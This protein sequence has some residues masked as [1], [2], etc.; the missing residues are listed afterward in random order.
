M[1]LLRGHLLERDGSR[2]KP[3]VV[4]AHINSGALS[5]LQIMVG[6]AWY[7]GTGKDNMDLT[8][9][10]ED[11]L[12]HGYAAMYPEYASLRTNTTDSLSPLWDLLT[13][14]KSAA[15]LC[16]NSVTSSSSPLASR[17]S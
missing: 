10:S 8:M 2:T 6:R 7:E 15:N 16:P 12:A 9:V 11:L 4:H 3:R 1:T 14:M 13:M 5:D 17:G